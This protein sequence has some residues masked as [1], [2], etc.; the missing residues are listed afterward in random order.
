MKGF[1]PPE[2]LEDT[3]KT[4]KPAGV[5]LKQEEAGPEI[6]EKISGDSSVAQLVDQLIGA[7]VQDGAS[8]IHIEPDDGVLRAAID[9]PPKLHTAV[10]SRLKIMG[11]LDIAEKRLPQYGRCFLKAADKEI[12]IRLSTLPTIFGEKAVMRI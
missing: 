12:D 8:D 1:N 2:I 5:E 9:F 6:L 4:P 10:I 11:N 3:A 7:A